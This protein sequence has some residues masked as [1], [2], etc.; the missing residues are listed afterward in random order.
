MIKQNLLVPILMASISAGIVA[1][2]SMDV[3]H[4]SLL[5]GLGISSTLSFL[6]LLCFGNKEAWGDMAA[7]L[8]K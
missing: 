6:L 4:M 3:F 7:V 5:W 2:M 1:V 8:Y